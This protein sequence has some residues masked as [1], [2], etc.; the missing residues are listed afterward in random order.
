V[1]AT[2]NRTLPVRRRAGRRSA[3]ALGNPAG[4]KAVEAPSLGFEWRATLYNIVA[5]VVRSFFAGETEMTEPDLETV[6]LWVVTVLV[7]MLMAPWALL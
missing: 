5:C 2:W 4:P 1:A 6:A 3:N 7:L